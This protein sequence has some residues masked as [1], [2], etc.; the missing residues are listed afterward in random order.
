LSFDRLIDHCLHPVF[1]RLL[2]TCLLLMLT[3]FL[4][5]LI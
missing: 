5:C 1:I 3:E 2:F 4:S